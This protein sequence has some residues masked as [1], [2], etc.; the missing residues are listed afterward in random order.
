MSEL[1]FKKCGYT[2][3]I[4]SGYTRGLQRYKCKECRHQ[5]TSTKRGGV[6]PALKSFAILSF[7]PL[8]VFLWER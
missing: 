4:K 3:Y 2:N 6:H 8:V 7:M 5:F 1:N